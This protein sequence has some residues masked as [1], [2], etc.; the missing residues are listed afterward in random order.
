MFI[1]LILFKPITGLTLAANAILAVT[2]WM[3]IWWVFE[4]VPISVTALLPIIL[5]PLT[6]GLELSPLQQPMDINIFFYIWVGLC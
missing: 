3:A 4:V 5:F 6:G 1:L 2:L